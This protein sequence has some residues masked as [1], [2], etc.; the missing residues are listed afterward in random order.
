MVDGG[1]DRAVHGC[2]WLVAGGWGR[3]VHGMVAGGWDRA[4]VVGRLPIPLL[5]KK[6]RVTV[7]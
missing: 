2:W 1:W 5:C 4:M 3:A 7:D 6:I